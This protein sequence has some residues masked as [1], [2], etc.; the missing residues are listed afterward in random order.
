[1]GEKYIS[2]FYVL[3]N[4][5]FLLTFEINQFSVLNWEIS[6]YCQSVTL[7]IKLIVFFFICEIFLFAKS[8]I[9]QVIAKYQS[10][11]LTQPGKIKLR[12]LTPNQLNLA[13]VN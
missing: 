11:P 6:K 8:K 1:M 5:Q 12:N 2:P 3:G 7:L 13:W 10:A 4:S 9:S